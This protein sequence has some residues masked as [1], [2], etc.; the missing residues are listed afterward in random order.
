MLIDMIHDNH[1]EPLFKTRYRD[2]RVL[3]AMGYQ[4]IVIPDALAALQGT[5]GEGMG[6]LSTAAV[7]GEA[8]SGG[9]SAAGGGMGAM[10][11]RMREL[12]DEIDGQVQWAGEAGLKIFF[13]GDA[14]L[15]PRVVVEKKPEDFL[16]G[17]GSGRL[18]PGK[19]EVFEALKDQV[20]ALFERW[21]AAAGL[22]MRTGEVYPEATPHM[23]GSP[24]HGPG[25]GACEACRGISTA[26]RLVR[27]I[28]K[29]HEAVIVERKKV[30][31][32]RA[33]QPAIGREALGG[34]GTAAGGTSMHD[35]PA[36]Y[37]EVAERVPNV[38][39]LIFSFKFT[40]GDFRQV[41]GGPGG[42]RFNPC[43]LADERP[44]WIEFQCEREY[45]GKGALPN[46]Q[47]PLWRQFFDELRGGLGI[48]MG[49][50]E[51]AERLPERF[52]LWGWS[53][54]GGWGGPYVQREEWID[55][56]VRAL[57][58]LYRNPGAD[59][60]EMATTWSAEAFGIAESSAPAPAITELLM[61]SAGTIRRLL[62]VAALAGMRSGETPWLKDDQLDVEAIFAAAQRVAALGS[63]EEAIDE[64]REAMAG[65]DRI[66]Q[67][68][69]IAS[70]ELPNKSQVR[71]L[72]NALAYFR[73]FAAT[74]AELFIGFVRYAQWAG[75]G[76]TDRG[77]AKEMREHLEAAQRQWQLHTQR[78]SQLPGAPSMF[79]EEGL[80]DRSNAC[81]AEIE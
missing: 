1:G 13:Y 10:P 60:A 59:P 48:R 45:E 24:L 29:M 74:V 70:P 69:D 22:V 56:N 81:L 34:I 68:F 4:A 33:W 30:Y 46:Y 52:H 63:A 62:Y 44:K 17:D 3:A 27:F 26:E 61:I 5:H 25:S 20:R 54:G 37:R 8:A 78:H 2:P 50:G 11:R 64:K 38:P 6:G 14:L 57:A 77:L 31:V 32:H 7:Q 47:G 35:D 40:R 58:E 12:E 55:A 65:V 75:T 49:E 19:E 80:W 42:S 18:C 53:R 36:V 41:D 43:L 66:V 9:G 15:L 23:R 71:D 76:R 72:F 67:L 28:G 21:P 39:E 51:T 73:S 79:H 16:C